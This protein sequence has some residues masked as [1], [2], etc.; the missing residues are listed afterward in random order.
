M[1]SSTNVPVVAT[2][3]T[4]ADNVGRCFRELIDEIFL[5]TA[6]AGRPPFSPLSNS[7]HFANGGMDPFD[8]VRSGSDGHA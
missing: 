1:H 2:V 4:F 3:C 7:I 8:K 5:R 6:S